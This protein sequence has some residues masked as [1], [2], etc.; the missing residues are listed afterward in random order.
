MLEFATNRAQTW[1]SSSV[2]LGDHALK[3]KEIWL[4]LNHANQYPNFGNTFCIL[5]FPHIYWNL[6]RSLFEKLNILNHDFLLFILLFKKNWYTAVLRI[7]VP[8]S[9]TC[10]R[11]KRCWSFT[12]FCSVSTHN[13]LKILAQYTKGFISWNTVK[14]IDFVK[15]PVDYYWV[16][17]TKVAR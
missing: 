15:Y 6:H 4:K 8:C 17:A 14:L 10:S 7:I 5:L 16:L 13:C 11:E 12:P 2:Y 9:K 3:W 1:D